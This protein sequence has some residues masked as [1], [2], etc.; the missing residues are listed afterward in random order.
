MSFTTPSA[1]PTAGAR[2]VPKQGTFHPDRINQ[3][4]KAMQYASEVAYPSGIYRVDFGTPTAA[5]V[6]DVMTA[7]ALTS[8]AAHT[9]TVVLADLDT[10]TSTYKGARFGRNRTITSNAA[11]TRVA[12]ITGRDYLNQPMVE[13]IT[14][15]GATTV[16]GKKAFATVTAI[17][18]SSEANTPTVSVGFGDVLGLPYATVKCLSEEANG[19]MDATL[20]TIVGPV[21]IDPQTA[22]TGDPRGTYDPHT[23]LDGSARITG[24]FVAN[25]YVNASGNG[26]LH[27]IKHYSA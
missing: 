9:G 21:T 8:G 19:V 3:Y 22:T 5:D 2:S 1:T 17:S 25:S 12:T 13:A 18:I 7:V 4:V 15:N 23:T 11:C 16:A 20:G 10:N 14:F 27:G 26:G 6:N 24:T